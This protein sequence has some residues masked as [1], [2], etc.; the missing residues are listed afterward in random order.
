MSG[1]LFVLGFLNA[2]PVT[3]VGWL[4]A[5]VT[6]SPPKSTYRGAVFFQAGPVLLWFYR[7]KFLGGSPPAANTLG[8][9]VFVGPPY[10][11]AR[12]PLWMRAH[13]VDGHGFQFMVLGVLMVVLYPLASLLAVIQGG[14]WYRDN[15]FEIAARNAA[16]RAEVAA[17][18]AEREAG[19]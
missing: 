2:L 7:W 1:L 18:K 17:L 8:L 3:L 15:G 4:L 9:A 5:L 16:S 14:H 12:P 6:L 13:E 10:D 11:A 19:E